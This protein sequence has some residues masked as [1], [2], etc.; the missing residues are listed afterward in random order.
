M[1]MSKKPRLGRGLDALLGISSNEK[2]APA[3]VGD[4][5]R[6]L[7][8]ELMQRGRYQPRTH[9]NPEALEEL[10]QSIRTHG[11]VQPILVRPIDGGRYE[12]IA[13]ERRWRAAQQAGLAEVP[14]HIRDVPDQTAAALGIIENIQREDLG[15]IEEANGFRRLLDEFK[16]THQQVADAVGRSRAAV[17]NLLRLLTLGA[18]TTKLLE[19]G[20]LEMGH[21]RAL[22]A[23]PVEQQ[24]KVAHEVVARGL[25]VRQTEMLVKHRLEKPAGNPPSRKTDPDVLRLQEDLSER[26][27]AKVHITHKNGKGE[28]IIAYNSLEELDGIL[29]RVR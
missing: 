3:P 8:V 15:P 17:T 12:I 22:L 14:V 26:L 19:D 16:L 6:R 21:A 18:E 25:N 29:A 5:E 13:G 23:L 2:P 20:K 7:P 4:R 27:G 24:D 11:V 1:N 28:L 10:A 9:M